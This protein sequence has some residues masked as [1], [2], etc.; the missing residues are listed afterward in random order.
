[1]TDCEPDV[2]LG[3][4]SAPDAMAVPWSSAL[5]LIGAA[6]VFWLTTVRP[7]GRPHVTPLLAAWS[8]GGMCFTTGGQE[9]KAANL[10][11]N[12]HCVLTTGTN[13][14][15]GVD[16]VIEGVASVVGDRSERVRAVADFERK[17]G[18]HLTDPAGSWNRLGEAVVDGTVRLYRVAPTVGFAFGK[19]PTSS[20]T[21][22]TWPS[23]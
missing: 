23:R 4:F 7:D 8:L 11:H 1:M 22:Y 15:T 13:A 20:Q 18:T 14:L 3:P 5:E 16:V 10:E 17:Y 19:L 21:R 2:A 6:E 12:P 9:R